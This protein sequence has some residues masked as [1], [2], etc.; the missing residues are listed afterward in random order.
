MKKFK[1]LFNTAPTGRFFGGENLT[2]A[3]NFRSFFDVWEQDMF[4]SM[5]II[6]SVSTGQK[7]LRFLSLCY[8]FG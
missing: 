1:K 3:V 4:Y 6:R 2:H 8:R 7:R 5:I